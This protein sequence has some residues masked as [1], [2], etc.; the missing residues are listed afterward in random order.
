M[1]SQLAESSEGHPQARELDRVLP[2][3]TGGAIWAK[4]GEVRN[5][6][7]QTTENMR[8]TRKIKEIENSC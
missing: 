8:E 6:N 7:A 2:R 1:L 4:P 5:K 3:V